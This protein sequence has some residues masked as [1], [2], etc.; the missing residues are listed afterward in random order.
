M[1]LTFIKKQL[2]LMIRNRQELIILLGM[3]LV[4]ISILG[5]ALDGVMNNNIPALKAKVAWIEHSNEEEDLSKL[6][7]EIK[8]SSIP[9]Y[10][11]EI[12]LNGSTQ[13]QP[14]RQLKDLLL[15]EE[16][17]D[18]IELVDKN[19][20]DLVDIKTDDEFTAIIEI[21]EQFSYNLTKFILLNQGNRPEL[22]LY[23]NEGKEISSSIVQEIITAFQNQYSM[24]TVLGKNGLL[25]DTSISNLNIKGAIDTVSNREPLTAMMYYSV[26]MCV[27]FVLFVASNIG[28]LAFREKELHVFDRIILGNVSRWSYF[29]GVFISAVIISFIQVMILYAVSAIAY[30]IHWPNLL[31]FLAVSLC[32]CFAVG[33][34]AALLTALNYRLNSLMMTSFFGN[35]LIFIF[36]FLGGSFFPAGELSPFIQFLGNLTPNGSGMTAYLKILQGYE[37]SD[38]MDS[39]LFLCSFSALMLVLAVFSFP[40]RG[41]TI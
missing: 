19:P 28:T 39:L 8:N 27:M 34:M 26:G 37:I 7:E 11:R 33:G 21:P 9:E 36:S 29:I 10:Q 2:L 25:N 13:L 31:G 38:I 1:I 14:V 12:L 16:L 40:K 5:F 15:S 20:N 22:S 17:S 32:V 6:A 24:L 30:G 23:K 3:P 4:L 41:K 35:V 18:H